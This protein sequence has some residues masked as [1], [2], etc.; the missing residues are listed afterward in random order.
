VKNERFW[1]G[2]AGLGPSGQMGQKPRL[3]AKRG[4]STWGVAT[5]EFWA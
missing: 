1:E 4:G 2:L 3:K 5:N